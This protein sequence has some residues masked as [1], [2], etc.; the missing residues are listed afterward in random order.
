MSTTDPAPIAM[1]DTPV[2]SNDKSRRLRCVVERE[3]VV[4]TVTVPRD[5]EVDDLKTAIRNRGILPDVAPTAWDLWKV[6][7][8]N[9]S[10]RKVI[11][12]TSLSLQPKDSNPIDVQPADSLAKSV[13]SLGDHLAQL[14]DKLDPTDSLDIIFPSQPR[15]EHIHIIVRVKA[16]GESELV[17]VVE[18]C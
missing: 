16:T 12:L 17:S 13:R 15:G 7:T 11:W 4:F 6:S 8:T 2:L 18:R 1:P 14:A 9:E 5:S 10:R 3:P